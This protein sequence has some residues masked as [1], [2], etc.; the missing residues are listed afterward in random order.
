M[1]LQLSHS[2]SPLTP[3]ENEAMEE[4]L[5]NHPITL[6][7]KDD[8]AL[9]NAS[10]HN[11]LERISVNVIKKTEEDAVTEYWVNGVEVFEALQETTS[12]IT[13]DAII[14]VPSGESPQYL[15]EAIFFEP[16]LTINNS[17][18]TPTRTTTNLQLQH[19]AENALSLLLNIEPLNL[20]QADDIPSNIST[21]RRLLDSGLAASGL[22][23]LDF[24]RKTAKG[25][26]EKASEEFTKYLNWLEQEIAK[27]DGYDDFVKCK[28]RT[29]QNRDVQQYWNFGVSCLQDLAKTH[30]AYNNKKIRSKDIQAALKMPASWF[31]DAKKG[32]ELLEKYGPDGSNE[33]TEVVKEL[34]TV[35]DH[36]KGWTA[37][38]KF[39]KSC[40]LKQ[41]QKKTRKRR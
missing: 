7:I 3:I 22:T 19:K 32:L 36:P 10:S 40:D 20:P 38:L 17:T 31:T 29:I 35:R 28:R 37:L 34:D 27:R 1:A 30:C 12:S 16:F 14:T 18:P 15:P 24:A 23:P 25:R 4:L 13:G 33:L 8:R 39:L 21:S 11:R 26:E 41:Q 9:H 5:E 2:G 6:F